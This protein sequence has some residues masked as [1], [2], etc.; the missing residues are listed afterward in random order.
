MFSVDG[1]TVTMCWTRQCPVANCSIAEHQRQRRLGH[2]QLRT[3]TGGHPAG[4]SVRT[5]DVVL[6]ACRTNV[7]GLQ[8]GLMEP[9][10]SVSKR[11]LSPAWTAHT[12]AL[13]A[14]G[15][16]RACRWCGPSAAGRRWI[17]RQRWVP[18]GG[19][20][21]GSLWGVYTI[22]QTSSNSRVFWIHLLEVCWTFAGSCK[23][24]IIAR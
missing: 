13:S 7:A 3:A 4:V 18:T 2:Q 6:T 8:P 14:S 1:G 24:P 10:R 15:N 19:G 16:W 21:T 20:C 17:V 23:H 11:R 9:C 12:R 22:Q 5:A